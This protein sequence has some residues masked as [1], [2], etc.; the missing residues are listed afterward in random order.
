MR[1][2]YRPFNDPSGHAQAAAVG[3]ASF[4]DLSLNAPRLEGPADR[5]AV[6]PAIGLHATGFAHGPSRL[7]ANRCEAIEQGEQLRHVV[8]VGL[9]QDGIHGRALRVDEEVV[10]AARFTAIGGVRSRFSP[11]DSA[12]RRTISNDAT[13]IQLVRAAELCQQQRMQPLPD[14]RLLPGA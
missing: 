6:T 1:P 10:L 14:A 13:K 7:A 8:S 11:M 3:C 12:D 4:C 2:G 9:G 5:F